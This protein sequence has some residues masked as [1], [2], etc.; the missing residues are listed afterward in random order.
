[1]ERVLGMLNDILQP[2]STGLAQSVER[3]PF[4][5]VVVGSSP[6]SGVWSSFLHAYYF[7]SNPSTTPTEKHNVLLHNPCPLFTL[8]LPIF[9]AH[10]CR[11]IWDYC[12]DDFDTLGENE[13]DATEDEANLRFSLRYCGTSLAC[14]CGTSPPGKRCVPVLLVVNKQPCLT[15]QYRYFLLWR[16]N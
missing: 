9:F 15:Q 12:H 7:W 14:G 3:W 6:I 8:T 2:S 11:W 10:D 5:P 16:G 1:M 4:K 13:G